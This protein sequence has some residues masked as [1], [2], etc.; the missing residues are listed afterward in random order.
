MSLTRTKGRAVGR[1]QRLAMFPNIS[2]YPDCPLFN[3]AA[4]AF[5]TA[6]VDEQGPDGEPRSPRIFTANTGNKSGI[7]AY[8]NAFLKQFCDKFLL[9]ITSHSFRHTSVDIASEHCQVFPFQII[10]GDDFLDCPER[11]LV[12]G[13]DKYFF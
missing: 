7:A 1:V 8:V 6:V 9:L 12:L 3:L 13:R 4:H 10:P 11:R 2:S 5:L